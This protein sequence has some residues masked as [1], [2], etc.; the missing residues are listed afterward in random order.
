MNLAVRPWII[1]LILG[2]LALS[3]TPAHAGMTDAE[4]KAFEGFKAKALKGD[5]DAQSIL[6]GCYRY[7]WGV[8]KDEVEA[9]KWFRVAANQ[10]DANAQSD[11]GDSYR[12]GW[13]V[14]KDEIE[15]YAF[16]NLAGIWV[17]H[18]RKNRDIL[19]KRLSQE[20]VLRGQQRT[21]ELQKEIEA[22][23][24]AKKAGK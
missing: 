23:I 13:G 1:A 24:A 20:A 14:P 15:A 21:K 10:G 19:E 9:V 8:A 12:S 6:G 4:V 7:G 5:S 2:L 17:E 16:Y 11:V 3:P 18:A 22:K